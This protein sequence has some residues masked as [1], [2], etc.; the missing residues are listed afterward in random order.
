MLLQLRNSI[1]PGVRCNRVVKHA[2]DFHV[3]P[4]TCH[5]SVLR[6]VLAFL[7]QF[8]AIFTL[9]CSITVKLYDL[10]ML[11]LGDKK[12]DISNKMFVADDMQGFY[13]RFWKV[14]YEWNVYI[15]LPKSGVYW[16]CIVHL[17]ARRSTCHIGTRTW[18]SWKDHKKN[19]RL[20]AVD[21]L[22]KFQVHGWCPTRS[23]LREVQ[24]LWKFPSSEIYYWQSVGFISES[25]LLN[26]ALGSCT[27]SAK[28]DHN[29]A[30]TV[31]AL[32]W[33]VI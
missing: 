2:C 5:L 10:E 18:Q 13:R 27:S 22:H 14:W 17:L 7:W 23:Q 28:S 25:G 32:F 16:T 31:K 12:F 26:K 20:H 19:K 9:W 4:Y 33:I 6:A 1:G 11:I 24:K 8:R 30:Q 3:C 15:V 21:F 29:E